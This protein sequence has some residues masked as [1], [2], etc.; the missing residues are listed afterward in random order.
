MQPET[1]ISKW[2]PTWSN[3]LDGKY[4]NLKANV[5][6]STGTS[7]FHS[8]YQVCKALFRKMLRIKNQY[9]YRLTDDHLKQ[10][11]RT[12]SSIVLFRFNQLLKSRSQ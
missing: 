9:R 2:I 12:A 7:V 11:M 1:I 3:V 5:L 6:K 10:F 8:T 4:P